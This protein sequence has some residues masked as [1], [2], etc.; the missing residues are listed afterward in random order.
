LRRLMA[1]RARAGARVRLLVPGR[2]DVPMSRRAA[3]FLYG[4]LLRAGVEIL[5]YRPQVLHAKL[6][7]LDDIVYVGSSNLDTRSLHLNHEIMVRIQRPEVAEQAR[8]WMSEACGRA[9][10]VEARTWNRSRG[11]WE[12]LREAWAHFVLAR[13]DPYLTRRLAPDPR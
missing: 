13:L 5:E 3:R 8:A 6:Y 10:R 1:R 12:R 7:R 2:T 11:R 4:G 9:D